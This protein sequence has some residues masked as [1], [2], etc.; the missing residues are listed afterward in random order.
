MEK[1]SNPKSKRGSDIY[2]VLSYQMEPAISDL[3]ND[4]IHELIETTK[5]K[6]SWATNRD[7]ICN[8]LNFNFI[9]TNV[10]KMTVYRI[11]VSLFVS[12]ANKKLITFD[13]DY[14]FNHLFFNS[15]PD[16]LLKKS[17]AFSFCYSRF[18]LELVNVGSKSRF[19]NVKGLLELDWKG[20]EDQHENYKTW[21]KSTSDVFCYL[22]AYGISEVA[23]IN[24]E[25]LNQYRISREECGLGAMSYSP[26]FKFIDGKYGG[27]LDNDTKKIAYSNIIPES[28]K[29][30]QA[31][32]HGLQQFNVLN[33]SEKIKRVGD[34]VNQ[35]AQVLEPYAS[36]SVI[37]IDDYSLQLSTLKSF[38]PKEIDCN[39]K[40]YRSQLDYIE[41]DSPEANTLKQRRYGLRYLNAYLFSYLPYFFEITDTVFKY[42]DTPDKFLAHVFV[43]KSLILDE[44][45][46]GDP[47]KKI[48]PTSLIDFISKCCEKQKMNF[49]S[50]SNLVR[51]TIAVIKRYFTHIV[52]L[53]SNLDGYKLS[54]NPLNIQKKKFG[55]GYNK[56]VKTKFDFQYWVYFRHFIKIVSKY[57]VLKA[58]IEVSSQAKKYN[59]QDVIYQSDNI[60]KDIVSLID[61]DKV[62]LLSIQE[63]ESQI[64]QDIIVIDEEINLSDN[65]KPLKIGTIDCSDFKR[66]SIQLTDSGVNVKHTNYQ[67]FAEL[68]VKCYAAQ[69]ASNAAW[70]CTDTFDADY[71]PN[72]TLLNENLV[73]IRVFTD[74]VSP[75]GLNSKVPKEVMELLIV[76][77][78]LRNLNRNK[79]FS[80]PSY[81]QNNK[82][83]KKDKL[84]PLLQIGPNHRVEHYN[85]TPF[86]LIFEKCLENSGIEFTS[87]LTYC[88]NNMR[89]SQFNYLKDIDQVPFSYTYKIQNLPNE[90]L[91]PFNSVTKKSWLT[92]HSLRTTLDSVLDVLVDD[93]EV[94]RMFTGQTDGTIGYYAKNTPEEEQEIRD[95]AKNLIPELVTPIQ[96]KLDEKEIYK[97]QIAGTFV[98]DYKPISTHITPEIGSGIDDIDTCDE[99]SLNWTH[100]CSFGNNCPNEVVR[101]IGRMKCHICPKA[102]MLKKH[103]PAIAAKIKSLLEDINY[104]YFRLSESGISNTDVEL[105]KFQIAEKGLEASCWKVRHDLLDSQ[106]IVVIDVEGVLKNMTYLKPG[107]FKE[108]LYYRLKEIADVPS[109]QSET[110]RRVAERISRKLYKVIEDLPTLI[111][112]ENESLHENPV[113]HAVR[114]LEIVAEYQGTTV[115]KLLESPLQPEN[116]NELLGVF[117]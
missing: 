70:L 58:G 10:E 44:Y 93:R 110:I 21:I 72:N 88:L 67:A 17:F 79:A 15:K 20:V 49:T 99:L 39:S 2:G 46:S 71:E 13:G 105:Y 112:F 53:Y 62:S 84:R 77:R 51:D 30:K 48:Y 80:E 90:S 92:G 43:T 117:K 6:A 81:Y 22:C 82:D 31:K 94:I 63:S 85:L 69:R 50:G 4:D 115:E 87:T 101:T 89:L 18:A 28:T 103:G 5:N 78:K 27:S 3:T 25:T 98:Q 114:T 47:D 86:I 23:E 38:D 19:N 65:L 12:A 109:L 41:H 40:W 32:K 64:N 26:V 59:L 75:I 91:V 60:V 29:R 57:A 52:T 42:P 116:D 96:V 8:K 74:K 95:T 83:T 113:A 55:K 7:S 9:L 108:S 106:D 97:S 56:S 1:V 24:P 107:S 54:A 76:I 104:L 16:S 14:C 102:L 73:D 37:F 100:I 35:D 33:R 61:N 45:I 111:D 36:A 66:K 11:L 34:F 68:V